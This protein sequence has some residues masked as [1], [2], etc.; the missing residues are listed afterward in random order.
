MAK[1]EHRPSSQP[2][3]ADPL[4]SLGAIYEDMYEHVV[5]RFHKAQNKTTPQ[6]L[7]VGYRSKKE[8][9]GTRRI[10]R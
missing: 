4:D 7:G 9:D 6:I 2:D 3:H 1:T 8:S 10:N 5:D